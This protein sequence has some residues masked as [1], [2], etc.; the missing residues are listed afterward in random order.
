V[1]LCEGCAPDEESE[2]A[3]QQAQATAEQIRAKTREQ[4]YTQDI[5][6]AEKTAVIACTHCGAQMSS[7]TKFCPECGTPNALAQA[8]AKHCTECGAKLAPGAKFC[9][10][11]GT[12]V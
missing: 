11:C 6:F 3:A 12:K 2:L 1:G 10:E 4:N 9:P 8:A 5:N 7:S